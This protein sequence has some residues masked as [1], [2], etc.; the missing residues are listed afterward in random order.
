MNFKEVMKFASGVCAWESV[1][2]TSF[3]FAGV[4]PLT[5]FGIIITPELNLIQSIIP[6]I[7]AGLLVYLAWFRK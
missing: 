3:G 1:V 5:L 2:H 6:A 4:L 7:V